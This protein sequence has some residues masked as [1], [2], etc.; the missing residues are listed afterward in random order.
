[1]KTSFYAIPILCLSLSCASAQSGASLVGASYSAP[2]AF[3]VAPGQVVTLF[4]NGIKPGPDGKLRSATA[5]VQALPVT[6]AGL[7]ARVTQARHA[8]DQ[9]I[10]VF[11]IRQ[12]N[13]CGGTQPASAGCVLTA[14]RVQIPFELSLEPEPEGRPAAPAQLILEED[15]QASKPFPLQP[16]VSNAHVLTS[17][18]QDWDTHPESA[19]NRL[20]FHAD[21]RKV[22][23]AAPAKRGEVIA[24]YVYG[25]GPT[26]PAAP[27]GK[28]APNGVEIPQSGVLRVWAELRDQPINASASA[29]RFFDSE[30]ASQPGDAIQFAGLAPGW[31]GLYQLN[32]LVPDDFKTVLPCGGE[33][34]ANAVA[35]ITSPKGSETVPLCV[36]H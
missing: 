32:I 20:A 35:L 25:L 1:M 22:N 27:T 8:V 33:I 18:D 11:S 6:L 30:A 15:G 3:E 4:F 24:V 21:G 16:V 13:Q 26:W 2:S 5:D 9:R 28:P 29:P 31:V 19:C 34:H 23:A 17:C 12:E 36:E 14:M 10:P 7:S